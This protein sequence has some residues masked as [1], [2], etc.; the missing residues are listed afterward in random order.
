[1]SDPDNARKINRLEKATRRRSP[2]E[3]AGR[4][5]PSVNMDELRELIALLRENGL[6]EF[7]LEREGF[8]VRLRRDSDF[9]VGSGGSGSASSAP[10]EK[11]PVGTSR[12]APSGSQPAA[13][14][15]APSH[16]GAQAESAASEDQDLHIIPSPIVGTFYRSSSPNAEPFVKI[17]SQVG[18]DSVVCIIEAMKLMNEIQ[19]EASGEVSKIYVENGQP[20]EYGQPLFGL[21]R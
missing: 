10:A 14:Q 8:R 20:V 3:N 18:P 6:A 1:M 15:I 4:P 19:A 13:A 21:K 12:T 7:E 11:S 9:L 16:P 17:G 2:A 5:E